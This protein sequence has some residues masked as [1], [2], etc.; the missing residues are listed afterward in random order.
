[1][2]GAPQ[3]EF[4]AAYGSSKPH[5]QAIAFFRMCASPMI[6]DSLRRPMLRG[7]TGRPAKKVSRPGSYR[8]QPDL[9]TEAAC[10]RSVDIDRVTI[11]WN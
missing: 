4:S 2:R 5:V 9:R 1:M 8:D 6:R 10:G 11:E 3:C 7:A